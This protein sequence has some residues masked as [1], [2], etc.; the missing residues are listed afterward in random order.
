M[1]L[2]LT[3][4]Q[5]LKA[6][7]AADPALNGLPQTSDGAFEVAAAYNLLKIP[8]YAVWRNQVPVKEVKQNIVWTEYIASVSAAERDAF[9]FMLSNGFIDAGDANIR[10]GFQDIFSGPQKVNTRNNMVAMSKRDALRIEALLAIGAGTN[11]SPSTLTHEGMIGYQDI[12]KAW[13]S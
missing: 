3:Q 12:V 1:S 6:D 9:V 11:G 5:I 13:G 10:Q 2:T 7:I 4:L 8:A